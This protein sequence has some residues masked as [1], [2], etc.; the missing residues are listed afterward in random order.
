MLML[1]CLWLLICLFFSIIISCFFQ[2]CPLHNVDNLLRDCSFCEGDR[3]TGSIR[4]GN[5]T[6]FALEGTLAKNI[7]SEG[8]THKYHIQFMNAKRALKL[9]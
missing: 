7:C 3:G 2:K 8:A 4:V 9:W 1:H 5:A 6:Q